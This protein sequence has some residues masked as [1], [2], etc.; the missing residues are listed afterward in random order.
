MTERYQ[1]V[2]RAWPEVVPPLTAQ[3]AV[4]AAKRLYRLAMGKPFAGKVLAASGNRFTWTRAGVLYVNP[5]RRRALKAGWHD[6]IHL[7]SHLCHKHLHRGH[8]PHDGRGT[9][10][11]IER[12]MIEHVVNSGWLDGK[13]K[14][15]E[16]PKA[17]I[18]VKA[19]RHQRVLARMATWQAKH[20]RAERALKKLNHQ[21][22]YYERQLAA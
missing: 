14:R 12:S 10:A 19:V 5:N 7:L 13:L 15:L 8:K 22:I 18:D 3:E 4:T 21:R 6:V 16:K 2:N 11:F 20:K 9:H 1:S 17:E